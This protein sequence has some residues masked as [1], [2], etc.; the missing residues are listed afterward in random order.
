VKTNKSSSL[1]AQ[2]PNDIVMGDVSVPPREDAIADQIPLAPVA[3][4]IADDK[5]VQPLPVNLD[6]LIR[7][8][9]LGIDEMWKEGRMPAPSS[10]YTFV[11]ST[12]EI[13]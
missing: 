1:Y 13:F 3:I 2:D 6:N 5:P 7:D 8:I 10:C 11:G 12:V 9:D 4:N